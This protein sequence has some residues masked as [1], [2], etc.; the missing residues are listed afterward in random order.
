[1]YGMRTPSA[2]LSTPPNFSLA[3]D[4]AAASGA[5]SRATVDNRREAI[6]SYPPSWS[7][8]AS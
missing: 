7:R 4:R 2:P 3:S 1:V 5:G 8:A 6:V